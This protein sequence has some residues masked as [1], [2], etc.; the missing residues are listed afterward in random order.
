MADRTITVV[1][2]FGFADGREAARA[3]GEDIGGSGFQDEFDGANGTE[4][5]SRT[6]TPN[7]G[8]WTA[9]S[10]FS[11]GR[12]ELQSGW[13]VNASDNP[14]IYV[15]SSGPSSAA[16]KI[17]FIYSDNYA[18]F[19]LPVEIGVGLRVDPATGDG[20]YAI[21]GNDASA[22]GSNY[23]LAK[24]SGGGFTLLSTA[25]KPT[26]VSGASATFTAVGSALSLSVNGVVVVTATDATFKN[27][28]VFAVYGV[29]DSGVY[30][31][32]HGKLDS[33]S[34][35]DIYGVEPWWFPLAG[36][37]E[38][39]AAIATGDAVFGNAAEGV[40]AAPDATSFKVATEAVAA[41]FAVWI[42]AGLASDDVAGSM[43]SQPQPVLR[44]DDDE[45][46][47]VTEAS[48]PPTGDVVVVESIDIADASRS[49]TGDVVAVETI[50]VSFAT[51]ITGWSSDV[52]ALTGDDAIAARS[53]ATEPPDDLVSIVARE[54]VGWSAAT[55]ID[56][57]S[58]DVD[59]ASLGESPAK[60]LD[61]ISRF[62]AVTDAF[63]LEEVPERVAKTIDKWLSV[64]DAVDVAFIANVGFVAIVNEDVN[65]SAAVAIGASAEGDESVGFN[66]TTAIVDDPLWPLVD[67]RAGD[68]LGPD[69]DDRGYPFVN[70]SADVRDLIVD[71]A[72]TI[73]ATD[74]APP[75]RLGWVGGLDSR[76]GWN[77]L[78]PVKP[79]PDPATEPP[80]ASLAAIPDFVATHA[81]DVVVYDADDHIVFD[82]TT[83]EDYSS[84]E[85][86]PYLHS[87]RW[88]TA[89][90]VM[91]LTQRVRF[92]TRDAVFRVPSTI[93]PRNAILVERVSAIAS[94]RLAGISIPS[95]SVV[96]G[97]GLIETIGGWNVALSGAPAP[98]GPILPTATLTVSAEPGSGMGR[99]PAETP[100]VQP[101][102][103]LAGGLAGGGGDLRARGDGCVHVGPEV[104]IVDGEA[105]LTPGVLRVEGHCKPCCRCEEFAAA[106]L[107]LVRLWNQ[108]QS[109]AASSEA[110]R[111]QLAAGIARWSQLLEPTQGMVVFESFDAV[112]H[113]GRYLD[114][115]VQA[116]YSG[117]TCVNGFNIAFTAAVL[118]PPPGAVVVA[119][120][121]S[122]V[123]MTTVCGRSESVA[124]NQ[125]YP[126][127]NVNKLRAV[128]SPVG[129]F[130]EFQAFW[131]QVQPRSSVE[132]RF[133]LEFAGL[134]SRT[135]TTVSFQFD[136]NRGLTEKVVVLV[137][138][139]ESL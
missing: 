137:K 85:Y 25:P 80:L 12:F 62:I 51:T 135:P 67:P 21:F 129:S 43:D 105:L 74:Y 10:G 89:D 130:V 118:G 36:K 47:I 86:G 124:I 22:L 90:G 121:E 120:D 42:T 107:A 81:A 15:S 98:A 95:G 61:S 94:R 8:S 96:G 70:P 50:N 24:L 11:S 122:S 4:L 60:L 139:P 31:A 78:L 136:E 112:L 126:P 116:C 39:T 71:V 125:L 103:D 33:F 26:K 106:A 88:R 6:A 84:G 38:I 93:K 34:G 102:R 27:S 101:I 91:R 13:V 97:S 35:G 131:P 114:V 52:D 104:A 134:D 108:L 9:V 37:V 3:F 53:D 99:P 17:D 109:A 58:V 54:F 133:R 32:N 117:S 16:A 18:G 28:G 82:S 65:F 45:S 87:H 132:L 29:Q 48:R 69:Y 40:D 1:D 14:S 44:F 113:S 110:S 19:E 83:A 79:P 64:H 138:P 57:L 128:V 66:E 20:Y 75:L 30:V 76:I 41:D 73:S 100:A 92:P 56:V 23:I 111:D 68:P 72:L 77:S 115:V 7:G 49:P 5:G 127:P 2:G 123:T 59:E 119:V 63:G 46:L 55:R